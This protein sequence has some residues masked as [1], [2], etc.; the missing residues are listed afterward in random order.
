MM[1]AAG[2]NHHS[3]K[4]SCQESEPSKQVAP[5][6]AFESTYDVITVPVPLADAHS[7][8][9]V[10]WAF[11]GPILAVEIWCVDR[12]VRESLE[13]GKRSSFIVVRDECVTNGFHLFGR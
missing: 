3:Q 8:R 7:V 11:E 9:H 5:I 1:A 2:R 4:P 6:K 13:Q 10:L 12:P